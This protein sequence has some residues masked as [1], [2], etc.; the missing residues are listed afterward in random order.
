MSSV[1]SLAALQSIHSESRGVPWVAL[2]TISH[3]DISTPHRFCMNTENVV[4]NGNTF[5]PTM[6]DVQLISQQG[7]EPTQVT[8]T[9]SAVDRT[10]MQSIEGLATPPTV[11]IE[12]VMTDDPDTI[13]ISAP[14]LQMRAIR[15]NLLSITAT[16]KGQSFLDESVPGV[17]MSRA[18]TP[19]IF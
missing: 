13:Q 19:G 18:T 12:F 11:T 6:M 4:S 9:L 7:G 16:L 1:L 5:I 15:T 8:L 14:N 10:I 3:P 2:V 17:L